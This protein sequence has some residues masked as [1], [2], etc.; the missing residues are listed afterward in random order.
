MKWFLGIG[1]LLGVWACAPSTDD[2]GDTYRGALPS[3]LKT[4]D[5]AQASDAY[6]IMCQ[7][8]VYEALYEY[9]YLQRPYV[10]RPLL[11]RALPTVTD[12]GLTYTIPIR[13]DV[14]FHDHA[15]FPGGVGRKMRAQDFIYSVKRMA[16]VRSQTFGWW[17]L[18]GKVVGLDDFR[19]RS[20]SLPPLPDTAI[21]S[22]YQDTVPG[23]VALDD[24]TVQIRLTQDI[25]YFTN[26]LAMPYLMVIPYEAVLQGGLEFHLNPVGTGPYLLSE[27]RQG[28]RLRFVRNPNYAHS[29]YPQEGSASDSASGLLRDAGARLPLVSR[30]DLTIFEETQPMWLNFLRRFLDRSSIPKDNYAEAVTPD[31]NLQGTMSERGIRLKVQQELDVTYLVFNF[32]DSLMGKNK[33]LRQAM[34]LA[35]DIETAIERFSNGRA[36]RAHS[37]LPPGIFGYDS[38]YRGTWTHYDLE[39]ARRKLAEAG[40]PEGKGLPELTYLTTANAEV[41]QLGEHFAQNMAQIGIR[42]KLDP[43]SW[44]EYLERIKTR[45]FQMARS[46]WQAD[47]PDP[48]NFLQL[49][50]GPNQPPGSNNASYANPRFDSLYRI[51]ATMTNTPERL[52]LIQ[53]MR[54]ILDDE[55]PWIPFTHRLNFQLEQPWMHNVKPHSLMDA[56]LK[57]YRVDSELRQKVLRGEGT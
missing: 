49:L 56:P 57:Y 40:F 13:T 28:L 30:I 54:A 24:S 53:Q 6:S 19:K 44:P 55:M 23:L 46:A 25:P 16:D 26:L 34:S 17:V 45:R 31:R 41:R 50:Y 52:N 5:P 2:L 20:E 1:V 33:A 38:T 11:A 48:E 39:A 29:F 15:C 43:C 42:V 8:Q 9:E 35:A 21:P 12:S 51:M 27:W 10:V 47:Y 37:P 18:E 32:H 22:L 7:F 3:N 14:R 4:L 36:I